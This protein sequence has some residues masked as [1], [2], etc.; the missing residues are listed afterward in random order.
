MYSLH[1]FGIIRSRRSP[2]LTP[3]PSPLPSYPVVR[4]AFLDPT[5]VTEEGA[6]SRPHLLA[7]RPSARL[8]LAVVKVQWTASHR[9]QARLHPWNRSWSSRPCQ[10]GSVSEARVMGTQCCQPGSVSEARVMGTQV[11]CRRKTRCCGGLLLARERLK[12]AP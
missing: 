1:F 7:A 5:H 11:R 6:T 10:P 4:Q 12:W 3:S 2:P 9:Q 8:V